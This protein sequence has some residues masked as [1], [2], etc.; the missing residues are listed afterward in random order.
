MTANEPDVERFT[1]CLRV[2]HPTL[3]ADEIEARVGQ[4]AKRKINVG[5]VRTRK[6]GSP[7]QNSRP[8]KHSL[9]VFQDVDGPAASFGD[10]LL[11]AAR[12]LEARGEAFSSL[13]V[14]GCHANFFVGYFLGPDDTSSGFNLDR[15]TLTLMGS[16]GVSFSI[17]LYNYIE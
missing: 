12:H 2:S 5:E 6:D 7:L 1:F 14:D 15:E 4:V 13:I 11:E 17:C 16:L 3:K 9:C 8:V 10:A